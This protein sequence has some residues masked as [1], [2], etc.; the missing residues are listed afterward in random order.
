MTTINERDAQFWENK[1]KDSPL[2]ILRYMPPDAGIPVPTDEDRKAVLDALRRFSL[3]IDLDTP[4]DVLE[5]RL[6][7]RDRMYF[8]HILETDEPILDE[9]EFNDPRERILAES[10][11]GYL[12]QAA[13]ILAVTGLTTEAFIGAMYEITAASSNNTHLSDGEYQRRIEK[14]YLAALM[15]LE[16]EREVQSELMRRH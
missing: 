9:E 16:M 8:R 6:V 2:G 11:F 1:M 13:F 14:E 10:E 3:A 15:L 7:H 12:K 5:A 4:D